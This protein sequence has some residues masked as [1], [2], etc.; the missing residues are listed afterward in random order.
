MAEKDLR[1]ATDQDDLERRSLASQQN[2][3]ENARFA[4]KMGVNNQPVGFEEIDGLR[5][6]LEQVS[7]SQETQQPQQPQQQPLQ[8]PPPGYL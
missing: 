2:Y 7:Q 4:E 6:F 5:R 8:N 3:Q 1:G